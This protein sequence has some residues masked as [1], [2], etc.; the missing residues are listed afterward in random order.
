MSPALQLGYILKRAQTVYS[1]LPGFPTDWEDKLRVS[2]PPPVPNAGARRGTR[3]PPPP[4]WGVG[5]RKSHGNHAGDVELTWGSLTLPAI[6]P[7]YT[8]HESMW[9]P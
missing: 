6:L 2:P 7:H 5:G 9:G 4:P 3:L 8:G 1:R